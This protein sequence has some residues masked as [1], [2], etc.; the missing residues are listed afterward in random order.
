MKIQL[1]YQQQY[2]QPGLALGAGY[3]GI[4]L[5]KIEIT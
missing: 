5:R 3:P 4:A 2:L 1:T